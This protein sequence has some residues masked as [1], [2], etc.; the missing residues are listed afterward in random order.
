MGAMIQPARSPSRAQTTIPGG[1]SW[2][3]LARC[4]SVFLL[5]IVLLTGVLPNQARAQSGVTS[6]TPTAAVQAFLSIGAGYNLRQRAVRDAWLPYFLSPEDCDRMMILLARK[7]SANGFAGGI[8]RG[9]KIVAVEQDDAYGFARAE[10]RLR[11]RSVW[12]WPRFSHLAMTLKKVE[13]RWLIKGPELKDI[14]LQEPG[15][16]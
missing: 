3:S 8:L 10:V 5:V 12:W 14:D 9:W 11:G 4:W 1:S 2:L 16:D 7:V 15:G 13:N 6:P